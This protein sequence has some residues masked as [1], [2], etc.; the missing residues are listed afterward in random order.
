MKRMGISIY[1][2]KSTIE[3]DKAYIQ[4]A[5]QYG[6]SRIFI[7]LLEITGDTEEVVNHF[8]EIIEYGNSLGFE[9]VVDI[10]PGLF[11][12]LGVSYD[13]LSFFKEL[14]ATAVRL[15][16]G[17]TGMEEARMTKNPY[18]L[19]IEVNMSSGTKYIDT[20][21]SYQPNKEKLTA[22][23]NFYP[24][25]YS[26][27]SQE[28]FEETTERFNQYR[29]NT[30]AFVTCRDG[31][32]GPWPVQAG[33]CT[34]EQHRTLSIQTQVT[35]YRLMD[36]INDLLIGN[37]YATEKELR[38]M[39]EAFSGNHPLLEIELAPDITDLEKKVLL[40]EVHMYRGDRSAYMIRSS[41]TRV[42]YKDEDFPARATSTIQRGDVLICSN[43][44]GQYKGETQIALQEMEG[45]GSRNIVG[46]LTEE[47]VFL[48]DYLAPWSTFTFVEAE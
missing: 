34:L 41:N 38:K 40:E 36:S 42:K 27:I 45:D 32:L 21:M 46:R 8:K 14:G 33:L 25:R 15:D 4:L 48:L 26:G 1:P 24:Q 43:D 11:Q 47:S 22:S 23:H 19:E 28:Q 20:I 10:N 13:D 12:Q 3:K 18:G 16:L 39:A 5:H 6:Y 2:L 44:L 31:E 30:A 29:L 35:H 17:F 7:S 9:T 37:A